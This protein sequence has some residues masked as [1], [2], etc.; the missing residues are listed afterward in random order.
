M[1]LTNAQITPE[2]FAEISRAARG[3]AF[4]AAS[5]SP[6][7]GIFAAY[8]VGNTAM[9]IIQGVVHHAPV[10]VCGLLVGLVPWILVLLFLYYFVFRPRT[11]AILA[12]MPPPPPIGAAAMTLNVL[13]PVMVVLAFVLNGVLVPP[14]PPVPEPP[15]DPPGG[16][17]N[18]YLTLLPWL[19]IFASVWIAFFRLLKGAT[20]NSWNRQPELHRPQTIH[21]AQD[22]ITFEDALSHRGY[23]WP[24][25]V[26]FQETPNLFVLYHSPFFFTAVPKRAF[27]DPHIIDHFR[28]LLVTSIRPDAAQNNPPTIQVGPPPLPPSGI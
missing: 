23:A 11:S 13:L 21:I 26:G 2:D 9:P 20:T 5:L 18:P 19:V 24:A 27:P 4:R 3:P 12:V 10:N 14:D 25:F 28:G 16:R 8:V 1:T 22:A 6:I 17:V 7:Y 15:P